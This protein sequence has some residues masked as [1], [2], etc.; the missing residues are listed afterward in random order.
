MQSM[1][2]L[3]ALML[4]GLLGHMPSVSQAWFCGG[5]AKNNFLYPGAFAFLGVVA[6]GNLLKRRTLRRRSLCVEDV[7]V[8][9][10]ILAKSYPIKLTIDWRICD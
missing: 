2:V 9:D 6:F 10:N 5:E 1:E 8:K 7:H 3:L 4:V